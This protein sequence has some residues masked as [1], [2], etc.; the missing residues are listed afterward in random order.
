MTFTILGPYVIYSVASLEAF[1][2]FCSLVVFQDP[3]NILWVGILLLMEE[4]IQCNNNFSK[5]VLSVI[6]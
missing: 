1:T 2:H 5:K 6:S 3:N 4:N